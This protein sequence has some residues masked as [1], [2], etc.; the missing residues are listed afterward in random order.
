MNLKKDFT[1]AECDYFRAECNFTPSELVVFNLRVQDKSITAIASA[2]HMSD[3]AVYT[4]IRNIKR[5]IIK[6]S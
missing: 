6:V 4:R 3:S 5:K 1:K 2:L